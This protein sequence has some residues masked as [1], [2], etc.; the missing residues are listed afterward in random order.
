[1]TKLLFLSSLCMFQSLPYLAR[2]K[3]K[4]VSLVHGYWSLHLIFFFLCFLC[5]T[6]NLVSSVACLYL[7]GLNI[8][9]SLPPVHCKQPRGKC[10]LS[11]PG[12]S[13]SSPHS[14][15]L[16]LLVS[17]LC[18]RTPRGWWKLAVILV[19]PHRLH[20]VA[21]LKSE[22]ISLLLLVWQKGLAVTSNYLLNRNASRP[23]NF[24]SF[25]FPGIPCNQHLFFICLIRV[26]VCLHS[27]YLIILFWHD[28]TEMLVGS[29]QTLFII[30]FTSRY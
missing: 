29:W 20:Q 19:C 6:F 30:L 17:A 4:P 12:P 18:S 15:Y 1:M 24:Y 14:R 5:C 26:N 10:S 8:L 27:R 7:P 2:R 25:Y 22:K 3:E 28:L 11:Q 9:L 23:L 13:V 16:I 21:R